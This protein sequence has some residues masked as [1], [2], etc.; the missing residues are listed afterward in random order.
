MKTKLEVQ[1]VQ[2]T[3]ALAR[4]EEALALPSTQINND[5]TIQRFEFSFELSWK[6]LQTVGQKENQDIFGP[7]QSIRVG[8]QMG[9]IDNPEQWLDFRDSRNLSTHLYD[10]SSS[11]EVYE[12][13]KTFL[14][15]AKELLEKVKNFLP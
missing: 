3:K 8:A 13:A 15:Q 4:L 14:P 9:L 7:T 10:E 5:A 2:L 6:I 11:I 12:S 1:V